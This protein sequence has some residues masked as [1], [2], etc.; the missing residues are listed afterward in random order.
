MA[1]GR[2]SERRLCFYLDLAA[3]ASAKVLRSARICNR[4]LILVFRWRPKRDLSPLLIDIILLGYQIRSRSYM[5]ALAVL[6]KK[7]LNQVLI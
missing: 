3:R 5:L 7:R 6:L 4:R 2:I 1:G